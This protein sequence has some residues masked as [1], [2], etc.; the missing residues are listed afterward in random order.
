M[1]DLERRERL[2]EFRQ[3]MARDDAK[4]MP[5]FVPDL[6]LLGLANGT[7][8]AD[9]GAADGAAR[10]YRRV[11]ETI[12][13]VTD[14][15]REVEQ[16]R[17]SLGVTAEFVAARQGPVAQ[18]QWNDNLGATFD[19]PGNVS[20][21][22]WGSGTMIGDDLFL[23]CG[24]LFDDDANGWML[25]RSNTTGEVI[26]PAEKAAN[27]HLNFNFQEDADGN[28]RPEQQFPITALVEYRVNGLDFAVCRVGGS[29]GA[30]FGRA[31]VSIEDA[32]V[33]D[34][35]CIIGHPAGMPKRIEAGPITALTGDAIRYDDIDTLGNNAG[36]G[37][38]HAHTG[39]LV[40]V[41]TNGGCNNAGTGSNSGVRIEAIL[42]ESPIVRGIA[43]RGRWIARQGLDVRQYQTGCDQLNALGYW[44]LLVD[45][46]GIGSPALY[47]AIW[48]KR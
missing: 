23:T 13:G 38:L 46:A 19:N 1:V 39:A 27:M 41:H 34:I 21:V 25:P 8:R 16:Y 48:E 22:R 26:T 28:L 7:R 36:S 42:H 5:L 20:A 43:H 33:D 31:A 45:A 15:S 11:Q 10:R 44:P 2:D 47:A 35:I 3:A 37:I 6:E 9:V 12:C 4:G 18:V 17:G 24:R 14:D 30:I 32:A 40:G 29:P